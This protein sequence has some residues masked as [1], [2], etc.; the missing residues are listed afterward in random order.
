[1][2]FIMIKIM[3]AVC[4]LIILSCVSFVYS[5]TKNLVLVKSFPDPDSKDKDNFLVHP[6]DVDFYRNNYIVTDAEECCLKIFSEKGDFIQKI[7]SKGHG[8]GELIDPFFS[9]VDTSTGNIYCVDQGNNRIV[10]Y[11]KNGKYL[12]DIKTPFAIDD[13]KYY[14]HKIYI[15]V[16]NPAN[17]KF[18]NIYDKEGKL[19]KSF[20][21]IFEPEILSLKFGYML[22]NSNIQLNIYN[23]KIY[24]IYGAL[25][26]VQVYDKHGDYLKTLYLKMKG[27]KKLYK[28]NKKG[29]KTIKNHRIEVARWLGGVCIDK[30]LF[31]CYSSY[32]SGK[33]FVFDKTGNVVDEI[34]FKNKMTKTE[35]AM[36]RF[37]RKDGNKFIFVDILNAQIKIYEL[38]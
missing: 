15:V 17:H 35:L 12:K 34:R 36:H 28:K 11:T 21:E 2:R 13:I 10:C 5:Q 29:A 30:G 9:A 14:R 25:P 16:N 24:A 31:Y 20:G 4:I 23:D 19:Y 32:F 6:Y 7:G 26:I 37:I 38:Q 1:M 18:I 8:P 33:L 3:R 27:W 22:V